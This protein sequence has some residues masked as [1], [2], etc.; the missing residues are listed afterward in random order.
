MVEIPMSYYLAT[1]KEGG[2]G[3]GRLYK[4]KDGYVVISASSKDMA[5]RLMTHRDRR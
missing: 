2:E 1:G 4:A 3:D 5:T